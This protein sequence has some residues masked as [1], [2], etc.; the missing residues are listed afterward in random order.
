MYQ[1]GPH[2]LIC[3]FFMFAKVY[4]CVF[5][6]R[7]H[8]CIV[9]IVACVRLRML[10]INKRNKKPRLRDDCAKPRRSHTSA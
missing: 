10:I 5:A 3:G 9:G 1:N 6:D 7:R 8:K 4:F 2:R